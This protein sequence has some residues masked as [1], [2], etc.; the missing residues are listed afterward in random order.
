MAVPFLV[1]AVLRFAANAVRSWFV[2]RPRTTTNLYSD[3]ASLRDHLAEKLRHS[4][5]QVNEMMSKAS[6]DIANLRQDLELKLPPA[7]VLPPSNMPYTPREKAFTLRTPVKGRSFL[8]PIKGR[9]FRKE[10]NENRRGLQALTEEGAL[11]SPSLTLL[12]QSI[13]RPVDS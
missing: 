8:T 5:E 11:E 7:L 3:L 4:R 1:D 13:A 12:P 10:N 9:A 2:P 6:A